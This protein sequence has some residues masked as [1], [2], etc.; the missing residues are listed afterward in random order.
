M[1]IAVWIVSGLLA[2]VYLGAGGTKLLR[3]YEQVKTSLEFAEDFKPWQVKA[4]GAVE[5]LGAIGLILP[6]LLHI[7]TILTPIAAVGLALVQVLAIVVHI[8][9]HD[10]P[11]R[12]PVNV[13]L[14]LAAV[15]VAIVRFA[16]V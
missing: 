12:I 11:K 15:F 3:P 5:V 4:I 2:L 6:E 14:L 10:N 7:A 1:L 8:R 13:I 9:R 16:G